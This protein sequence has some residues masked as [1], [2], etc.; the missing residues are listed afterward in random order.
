MTDT[1]RDGRPIEVVDDV[2]QQQ[3][4]ARVEGVV[5]GK[6]VYETR[7]GMVWFTHTEV[8]PSMQGQGVANVLARVALDDVRASGRTIVPLCPFISAYIRRHPAYVDLVDED[9][10]EWVQPPLG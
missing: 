8:D 10:R 7:D 9:H 4:E 5:V 6:A 2:E 3:F 1:T